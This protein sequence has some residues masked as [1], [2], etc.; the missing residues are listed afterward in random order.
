MK[1][2]YVHYAT[3]EKLVMNFNTF[4]SPLHSI[5]TEVSRILLS[6]TPI[7]KNLPNYSK[8][9]ISALTNLPKIITVINEILK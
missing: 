6:Q 1:I 3:W 5:H 7:G 9:K 8:M 4:Y 2:G